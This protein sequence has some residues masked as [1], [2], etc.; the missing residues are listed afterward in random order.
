MRHYNYVNGTDIKVGNLYV[1]KINAKNEGEFINDPFKLVRI[2]EVEDKGLGVFSNFWNFDIIDVVTLEKVGTGGEYGFMFI[3]VTSEEAEK[4]VK[5]LNRAYNDSLDKIKKEIVVQLR[6][7]NN[8]PVFLSTLAELVSK[9]LDRF[10]HDALVLDV[11][12]R[13]KEVFEK[14]GKQGL[15]IRLK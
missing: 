2:I 6:L 13:D 10:I 15:H 5:D 1:V 11:V 12:N 4:V 8:E 7:N 9:V 14:S 3:P